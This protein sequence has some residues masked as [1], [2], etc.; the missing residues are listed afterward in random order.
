MKKY[1]VRFY[2][3][4]RVVEKEVEADSFTM[5]S[6]RGGKTLIFYSQ[7]GDCKEE[8]HAFSEFISVEKL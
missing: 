7:L 6:N 1:K 4:A 3:D 5:L 2:E 8:L